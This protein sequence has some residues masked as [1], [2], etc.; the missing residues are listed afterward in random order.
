MTT[1]S[2]LLE[3][4]EELDKKFAEHQYALLRYDFDLALE[5]LQTYEAELLAHMADEEEIL[6]PIYAE[7]AEIESG[8]V[9]ELFLNEH[10]KMLEWLKVFREATSSLKA[11]TEREPI[12]IRLLDRESFFKKL[13][14]HHDIRETKFLYP[15]LDKVV[16]EEERRQIFEKLR[17][18][19]GV[20]S[21]EKTGT[22]TAVKIPVSVGRDGEI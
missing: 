9:V 21:N 18:V 4:H 20:T 11:E 8:G 19:P 12:L 17:S 1:F 3:L 15:A 22:P 16:G 5:L 14:T 6:I 2:T 10:K 7:R 13:C